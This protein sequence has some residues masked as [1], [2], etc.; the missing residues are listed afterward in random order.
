M[1]RGVEANGAPAQASTQF[2]PLRDWLRRHELSGLGRAISFAGLARDIAA[3]FPHGLGPIPFASLWE[4][5]CD[6]LEE[7]LQRA[8]HGA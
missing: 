4:R 6:I 1:C 7:E 5:I 3:V 8:R 2:A